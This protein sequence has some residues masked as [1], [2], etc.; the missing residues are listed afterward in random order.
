MV[1]APLNPI[2][3]VIFPLTI[4]DPSLISP[5]SHLHQEIGGAL[6]QST[7]AGCMTA[8]QKVS[9]VKVLMVV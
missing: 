3:P 7:A 9:G 5:R 6:D 1:T 2:N 4:R 8:P